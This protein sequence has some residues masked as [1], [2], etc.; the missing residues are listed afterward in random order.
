[1]IRNVRDPVDG[2][3]LVDELKATRH[4]PAGPGPF[5][6]PA[7]APVPIPI[8]DGHFGYRAPAIAHDIP[9]D[10]SLDP[11]VE[12]PPVERPPVEAVFYREP[13]IPSPRIGSLNTELPFC[14]SDGYPSIDLDLIYADITTTQVSISEQDRNICNLSFQHGGDTITMIPQKT[15]GQ[16]SFGIVLLYGIDTPYGPASVAVKILLREG[17][18][19]P[20]I[21][22]TMRTTGAQRCPVINARVINGHVDG[23][24]VTIVVMNAMS[25]TLQ[26]LGPYIMSRS[27]PLGVLKKLIETAKCLLDHGYVYTDYKPANMLYLCEGNDV[28]IY[29][30]DLGSLVP[31]G[32]PASTF[33]YPPPEMGPR[34]VNIA[35]EATMVWGIAITFILLFNNT[36][37]PVVSSISNDFGNVLYHGSGNYYR[38]AQSDID[39]VINR[40]SVASGY[41]EKVIST[42]T[43][44][45]FLVAMLQVNPADRPT[46]A[47]LLGEL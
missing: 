16:G 11:P 21:I 26:D 1:M 40:F 15:L 31:L 30:G 37:N 23:K 12:R 4:G 7:S 44:E 36:T 14:Q 41:N 18:D 34:L 43:T 9:A 6:R 32:A 39:E 42:M 17:D 10:M 38:V 19:E 45:Q 25:G 46:L 22:N 8:P 5:E 2:F 28:D 47:Q 24:V 13:I 33:T 35:T 20:D 27:G 3:A 29:Y